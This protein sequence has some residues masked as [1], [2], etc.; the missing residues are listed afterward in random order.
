MWPE[1]YKLVWQCHQLLSGFL[2]NGHLPRVSCQSCL[3]ANDK[4][5]NEMILGPVQRSPGIYLTAD[6]NP[7]K[8][9]LGEGG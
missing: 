6:E 9:Q 2:V 3:S 7:G 8:S 5:D 4:G 1:S